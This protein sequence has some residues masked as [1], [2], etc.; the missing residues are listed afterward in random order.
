[1]TPE[2]LIKYVKTQVEMRLIISPDYGADLLAY[3]A[4]LEQRLTEALRLLTEWEETTQRIDGGVY[5]DLAEET[6][7]FLSEG[8]DFPPCVHVWT[9]Q[10][11]GGPPDMAESAEW[12]AFCKECGAEKGTENE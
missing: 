11:V 1:M 2:A 5:A 12:V 3:V 9:G 6:N 8:H 10:Q 4:T 7:V